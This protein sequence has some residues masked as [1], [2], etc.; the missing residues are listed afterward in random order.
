[1]YKSCHA[2][3]TT[4]QPTSRTSASRSSTA[5]P[6]PLAIAEQLTTASAILF[7]PK[8]T[9]R[10]PPTRLRPTY[11]GTLAL[12]N[13]TDSTISVR[14]LPDGHTVPIMD[15]RHPSSFQQLEKLGEGT[16]ATVSRP[17]YSA[18]C[19]VANRHPGL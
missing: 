17:A 10:P 11:V 4:A 16:Y 1:M 7:N 15:K 14:N 2:P 5:P 18:P 8:Y 6:S 3:P 13:R 12:N 19:P 9:R